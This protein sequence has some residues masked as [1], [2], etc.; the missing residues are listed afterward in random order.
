MKTRK[1]KKQKP[2]SETVPPVP[3]FLAKMI[4]K[5]KRGI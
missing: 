5:T 4:V 3:K 1:P 2:S